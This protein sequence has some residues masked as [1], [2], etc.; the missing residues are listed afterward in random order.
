MGLRDVEA[1]TFSRQSAQE[2]AVRLSALRVGFPALISVRG[3][4]DARAIVQMEGLGRQA[5][6]PVA[7]LSYPC[8]C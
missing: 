6:C 7:I 1:P 8:S 2:M 5:C 4:L 3:S